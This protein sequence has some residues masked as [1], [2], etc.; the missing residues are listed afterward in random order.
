MTDTKQ[1]NLETRG[2]QCPVHDGPASVSYDPATAARGKQAGS[3]SL[4]REETI[5]KRSGLKSWT[6]IPSPYE[7][8]RMTILQTTSGRPNRSDAIPAGD[9]ITNLMKY[10]TGLPPLQPCGSVTTLTVRE[11]DGTRIWCWNGR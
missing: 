1:Q 4:H 6:P 10:A 7:N 5:K 11:V 3:F 9:G 8:G 2:R